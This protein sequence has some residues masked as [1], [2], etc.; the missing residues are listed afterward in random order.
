MK[1]LQL[2]K[3]YPIKGGVEKVMENLTG[4]LGRRGIQCDMLCAAYPT[5]DRPERKYEIR[6]NEHARIIVV[7]TIA[8]VAATMISPANQTHP[9]P[10]GAKHRSLAS[11]HS[12]QWHRQ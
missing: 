6:I 1:V 7:P 4:G 11:L 5:P 8:N 3:F 10:L 9:S 12:E 2:G